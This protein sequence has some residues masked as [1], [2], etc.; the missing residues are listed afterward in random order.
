MVRKSE[1][2]KKN[3]NSTLPRKENPSHE[4]SRLKNVPLTDLILQRKSVVVSRWGSY[5]QNNASK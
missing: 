5:E 3:Q 4:F 1:K 2:F